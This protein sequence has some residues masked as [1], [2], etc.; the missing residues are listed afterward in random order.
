[1]SPRHLT[2]VYRAAAVLV[3]TSVSTAGSADSTRALVH[4]AIK[5]I[6][7]QSVRT[8]T[9]SDEDWFAC[10]S[11]SACRGRCGHVNRQWMYER[12]TTSYY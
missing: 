6:A 1:M 2:K 4:A 12:S 3:V 11:V 5:P 9:P 7:G 8:F 10:H